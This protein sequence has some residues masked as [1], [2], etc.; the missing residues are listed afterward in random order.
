MNNDFAEQN[1]YIIADFTA[2]CVVGFHT[3]MALEYWNML[4]IYLLFN[5]QANK[6]KT[7]N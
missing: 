2:V 1:H 4:P 5:K 7:N 6:Q 3:H